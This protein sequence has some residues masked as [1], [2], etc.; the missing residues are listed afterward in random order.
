[1]RALFGNWEAAFRTAAVSLAS[2]PE[3]KKWKK[4]RTLD[5]IGR[6]LRKS[7]A[8]R[9]TAGLSIERLA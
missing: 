7:Y 4:I 3:E 2:V 8:G 9:A 6:H 1:L 5:A